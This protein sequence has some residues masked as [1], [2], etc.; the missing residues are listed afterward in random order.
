M[1]ESSATN[2]TDR[3]GWEVSFDQSYL[4]RPG[5]MPRGEI[6]SLLNLD[7][8]RSIVEDYCRTAWSSVVRQPQGDSNLS[9]LCPGATYGQLWDWDAYWM[10]VALPAEAQ[11]AIEGSIVWLLSETRTDGRPP[12]LIEPDGT[13]FFGTQPMPVHAQFVALACQR[14]GDYTLAEKW[15]PCLERIRAWFERECIGP[16][17]LLVWLEYRGNGVDNNPAV[18]GRPP[19]SVAGGDLAVWH[20]REYEAMAHLADKLGYAEQ[21]HR[22][23]EHAQI[24]R[25]R[26]CTEYWDRIDGMFYALD[27]NECEQQTG[28]QRVTWPTY[29]KTHN[30]T[31]FFPLW[32]G[33]AQQDQAAVL[34]RR[35]M[36]PQQFLSVAG[37]RS[38]SRLDPVYNNQP[39]G[40]PSNWQGPV[41]ILNSVLMAYGLFRYG[42]K[43]DALEVARRIV[44]RTAMDIHDNRCMHE[45][46]HGDTGQPVIKP[47]FLSWNLLVGRLLSDLDRNSLPPG[48]RSP[49]GE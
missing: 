27:V 38:Q 31:S 36:D 10:A 8:S 25:D 6:S 26:I 1:T 32:A 14:R 17:G 49:N 39:M 22:A 16:R 37:V 33:L 7:Q 21:A 18:Y 45:C 42:Y 46:Y 3:Y 30:W 9:F 34:R 23:R 47:G 2:P 4:D 40:N 20:Q 5:V 24:L 19:R 29:L 41:W 13:P 12:K 15:W 48:L 11:K 28:L 43:E 44:Q 35:V